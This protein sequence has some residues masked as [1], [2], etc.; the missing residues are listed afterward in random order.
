MKK[1]FLLFVICFICIS[2]NGQDEKTAKFTLPKPGDMG[3]EQLDS[4]ISRIMSMQI[5]DS[6]LHVIST[7]ELLDLCLDYPYIID[8]AF[9]DNY[10]KGMKY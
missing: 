2:I 5:P 9:S 3:W 7:E 8:L 6:I 4:P 10:Q 1:Y